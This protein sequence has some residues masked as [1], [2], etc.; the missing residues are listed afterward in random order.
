MGIRLIPNF[1]YQIC[2]PAGFGLWF[3]SLPSVRQRVPHQTT[4]SHKPWLSSE[5]SL[6][7]SGFLHSFPAQRPN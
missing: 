4:K 3:A 6:R 5:K 7:A 1:K 2:N